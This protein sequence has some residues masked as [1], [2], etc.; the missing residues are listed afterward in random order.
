MI[1]VSMS[2][3][4]LTNDSNPTYSAREIFTG[5]AASFHDYHRVEFGQLVLT[6]KSLRPYETDL[7]ADLGII[8]N[9]DMRSLGAACILDL[10]SRE[11]KSR[12]DYKPM[13]WTS[14]HLRK[15][16]LI[17]EPSG[18]KRG[19]EIVTFGIVDGE[20]DI[21]IEDYEGNQPR[22]NIEQIPN[23]DVST[24]ETDTNNLGEKELWGGDQPD[25]TQGN[26]ETEEVTSTE[27]TADMSAESQKMLDESWMEAGR[28]HRKSNRTRKAPDHM[29]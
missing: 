6:H 9:R 14:E 22:D 21:P 12:H 13:A 18:A 29:Q 26:M 24:M 25:Q 20:R 7:R 3:N 17:S 23:P 8:V 15:L 1:Y 16:Y 2:I 10:D 4:L 28:A 27:P 11:I 19:D 5:C